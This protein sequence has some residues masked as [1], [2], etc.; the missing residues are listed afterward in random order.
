MIKE[1]TCGAR[2][3]I[4]SRF[5]WMNILKCSKCG[6]VYLEH[7]RFTR[8]RTVKRVGINPVKVRVK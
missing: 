7:S 8:Y 6:C 2:P 4:E 5:D 1:C 3:R